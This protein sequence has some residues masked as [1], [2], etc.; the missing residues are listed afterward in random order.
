MIRRLERPST[1]VSG[2]AKLIAGDNS[3]LFSIWF[4]SWHRDYETNRDGSGLAG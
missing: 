3:C 1:Y 4:K 2:L